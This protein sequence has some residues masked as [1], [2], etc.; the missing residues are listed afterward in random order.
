M[1]E[2]SELGELH[3]QRSCGRRESALYKSVE[4]AQV[5]GMQRDMGTHGAQ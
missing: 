1:A 5:A 3:V 2:C 4:E